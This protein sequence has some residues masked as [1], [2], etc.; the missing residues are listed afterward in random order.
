[1]ARNDQKQPPRS[2][3]TTL[4]RP[5]K[6]KGTGARAKVAAIDRT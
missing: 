6:V 4:R 5:L 1:M 2:Q 3:A